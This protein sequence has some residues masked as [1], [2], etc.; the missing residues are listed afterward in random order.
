MDG[1]GLLHYPKGALAFLVCLAAA[2]STIV[3]GYV[4]ALEPG[5]IRPESLVLWLIMGAGCESLSVY[6]S[7]GNIYVS[8]VEAVLLASYLVDGPLSCLVAI[9]G[10]SLLAVVKKGSAWKH[11]FN[12]PARLTLFNFAHF[13]VLL[14]CVDVVYRFASAASGGGRLMP[15]VMVAPFFFVGSCLLNA[16][17]YLLE[18]GRPFVGYFREVFVP[19]V[20]NALLASLAAVLVAMAF[21]RFGI[22]SVLLFAAP[23]IVTRLSFIDGAK[24]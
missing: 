9:S 10:A 15:A 17:F 24:D 20:P 5:S 7:R 14:W 1:T 21:P 18:E 19:Y 2:S 4:G 6:L 8:T 23:F 12:Y 13:V 3:L 11:V 16:L 22:V